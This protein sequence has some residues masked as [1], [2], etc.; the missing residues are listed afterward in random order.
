M[1]DFVG[2]E[3]EARTIMTNTAAGRSSLVVG[4]AGM[5]KSALLEW[6]EPLLKE[7]GKLI[8]IERTAPFGTFLRALFDGLHDHGIIR[9]TWDDW[10]KAYQTNE[11][12]AAE[13]SS[14][15]AGSSNI[16]MVIDDATGITPSSRPWL[17][18]M[19]EQCVIIAAIDP[20]ALSKKGTKRFWK[21][22]DEILLEPLNKAHSAEMLDILMKK[23][24]ITADEP[25]IYR[26]TVL[27]LAQGVPFELKRLVKNHSADVL[28]KSRDL[29]AAT[30]RYVDRDVKQVS[31]APLIFVL[32]AF[33]M[34]GRYIARVQNDMDGYVLSALGLGVLIIFGPAIRNSLKP[35]TR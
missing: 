34:A 27:D 18:K 9:E 1:N 22:F 4:K 16:I 5:G 3:P 21:L 11:H 7:E 15:L 25:D 20:D 30:S 2:R 31:L 17:V 14:V 13:L 6:L 19:V 8:R 26:R 35:R 32:G 23:Y 33:V 29:R 10:R 12:K 28:V 24:N